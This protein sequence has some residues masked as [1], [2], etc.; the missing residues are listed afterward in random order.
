VYSRT[1]LFVAATAV[2]GLVTACGGGEDSGTDSDGLQTVRVA[3]LTPTVFTVG[4]PHFVAEQQGFYED[5]GIK[6]ETVFTD[7]GGANVQAVASGNADIATQT[8]TSAV[9]SAVANGAELQMIASGFRGIDGLWLA[10]PDSGFTD[11]ESLAGQKVGFTSPGSSSDVGVR[12][13]SEELASQGLDPLQGEAVGGTPDQLTAMSTGQIAA[14]YTNPPVGIDLILSGEL[15]VA[16][17]GFEELPGYSDVSTRV[18]FGSAA[19]IEENP[20][21]VDAWIEAMD[22][23]WDWIFD[24]QEEAA[25]IWI[26]AGELDLTVEEVMATFDYY[27]RALV[28]LF[29]VAG[30]DK[31]IADA[32]EFG[33]LDEPLSEE[34]VDALVRAEP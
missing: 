3:S 5:A 9:M 4:L 25:Q 11:L 23:T 13:F 19:F 12:A 22:K 1:R 24:N 26:E 33:S 31:A 18:A 17:N 10:D 32:V 34:Q 28:E 2:L 7:G 21:A 29:P 16:L 20:E 14:A 27:D 8:G 6:V 15:V 30:L